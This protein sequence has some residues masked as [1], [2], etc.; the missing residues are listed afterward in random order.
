MPKGCSLIQ[1]IDW[2]WHR[3]MRPFKSFVGR[4]S[5]PDNCW[6]MEITRGC[7]GYGGRHGANW[8]WLWRRNHTTMQWFVFVFQDDS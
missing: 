5:L 7:E 4:R 1:I 2:D 3:K 6:D 8:R